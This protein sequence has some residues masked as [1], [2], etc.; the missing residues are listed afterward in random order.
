MGTGD[1]INIGVISIYSGVG[2]FVGQ[3]VN[4]RERERNRRH[5]EDR[6]T[7]Q[8]TPKHPLHA[9]IVPPLWP[10]LVK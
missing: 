5:R 3:L 6:D 8:S 9:V 7:R 1:T 2:A 4:L 10:T